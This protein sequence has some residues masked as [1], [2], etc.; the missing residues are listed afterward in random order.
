LKECELDDLKRIN[1]EFSV[2]NEA[3]L[4]ENQFNAL[5]SSQSFQDAGEDVQ[6]AL[7]EGIDTTLI[8][9]NPKEAAESYLR[10]L[11][12]TKKEL[13][14]QKKKNVD[15]SEKLTELKEDYD[16]LKQDSRESFEKQ[17]N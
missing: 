11:K 14:I 7:E 6:K 3:L 10:L 1:Q 17:L 9:K 5:M 15:L 8:E 12:R 13:L 16:E 2:K 4:K